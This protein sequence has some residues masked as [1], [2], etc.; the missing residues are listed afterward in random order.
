MIYKYQKFYK[1]FHKK[2]YTN[3]QYDFRAKLDYNIDIPVYI[4]HIQD[5]K[6]KNCFIY[7]QYFIYEVKI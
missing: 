3:Y 7:L 1:L 2:F 6:S 5:Y 4:L